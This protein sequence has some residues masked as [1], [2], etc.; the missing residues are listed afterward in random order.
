VYSGVC[1]FHV[2]GTG[3]IPVTLFQ[4]AKGVSVAL[5]DELFPE[6]ALKWMGPAA[7]LVFMI[8]LISAAF[9]SADELDLSDH[10][11]KHRFPG[12]GSSQGPYG[13]KAT[14]LRYAVHLSIAFLFFVSVLIF[15]TLNDEAVID[16][17]LRLPGTHTDLC[18]VYIHSDSLQNAK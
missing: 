13:K 7:G 6:I 8:G 4:N 18:W 10:F 12:T 11:C 5:S 17:L 14:R 3:C 9:P 15:S 2:S 1:Q 16:K